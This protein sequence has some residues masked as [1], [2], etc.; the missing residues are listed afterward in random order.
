MKKKLYNYLKE[1]KFE[2]Q[3]AIMH[4]LFMSSKASIGEALLDMEAGIDA[5]TLYVGLAERM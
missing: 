3:Y 5:H 4:L 1:A 2:S